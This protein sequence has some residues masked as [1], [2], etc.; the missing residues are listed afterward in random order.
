[1]EI[2]AKFEQAS[3][4]GSH[5]LAV[6][7]GLNAPELRVL[8]ERQNAL[9]FIADSMADD[10]NINERWTIQQA[11]FEQVLN[12]IRSLMHFATPNLGSAF[13][14]FDEQDVLHRQEHSLVVKA[15]NCH[16]AQ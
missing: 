16:S 2:I 11:A 6:G 14:Q 3:F 4:P 10:K 15:I 8:S 5:K 9:H 7:G 13:F 12:V 1:M